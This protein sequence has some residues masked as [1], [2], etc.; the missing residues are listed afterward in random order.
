M[1][2]DAKPMALDLVH[3]AI[4]RIADATWARRIVVV[5][6][7]ALAPSAC[8]RY[9]QPLRPMQK[10]DPKSAYIYG[11]FNLNTT[12]GA[13]VFGTETVTFTIRCRDGETYN[14]R[15][16][17]WKGVQLLP[18]PA[19]VCQIEDVIAD[20][21]SGSANAMA[22]GFVVGGIVGAAV[23][24]MAGSS[25]ATM[26]NFRLLKNEFLDGGGVYYV[27]DFTMTAKDNLHID[28]RHNDWTMRLV[29]NYANATTELKR[30]YTNFA[31]TH[32]ENRVSH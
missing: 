22:I 1:T 14:L 4:V 29:D 3:N 27:G 21:G 19:S 20:S 25:N 8:T 12:E 15:F 5:L 32:T 9:I 18:L 28:D 24:S 2:Y 26:S 11:R 7:L 17:H 16:L 23:G 13:S 10:V 30:R 6:I 31:S